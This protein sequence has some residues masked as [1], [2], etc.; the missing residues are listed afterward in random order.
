M[1]SSFMPRV[2]AALI[3]AVLGLSGCKKDAPPPPSTSTAIVPQAT[4]IEVVKEQER[5]RNFL[6]VS[7]HL[8]LGGTVYGYLDIDGDVFKV[9]GGLQDFATQLGRTQPQL[10]PLAK[11][12][13]S[14]LAT[15]LGLA[16]I[17]AIGFSSV[18]DGTGAFRNRTFL[19]TP[20][21][22]HGLLASLGGAPGAFTHLK[23][24]PADASFYTESEV[25]LAVAWK[26]IH[27]VIAK[28]GG[29][30]ATTQV[31]QAMAK[32]GEGIALS[33][34][35]LIYGLKGHASVVLRFDAA[36]PLVL[37]GASSAPMPAPL[38][39]IS[40]DG[41][42]PVVEKSLAQA[43]AFQR[44]DRGTQHLYVL[45]QKLPTGVIQPV[46]V[47]DGNTLH[48]AT[49]LDFFDE[50]TK[51][52]AGL[53][54]DA[55]FKAALGSVGGQGN[56]L[57]YVSPKFFSDLRTLLK[58]LPNIPP[59]GQQAVNALAQKLPS[60]TRPM[61]SVRTNLPDGILIQSSWD[62]SL[63]QDIV[64]AGAANPVT[65]GFFAAMAIPAFQKVR[66]ASQEKAILN[67][68]RQLDAAAEQFYL[69]NGVRAASYNDLV[70][71]TRYIR[72]LQSVMGEDYRR[73]SFAQGVPLRLVLPDGRIIQYPP[74]EMRQMPAP[75]P[76]AAPRP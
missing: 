8:E 55:A 51:Q 68:L 19:Y 10:A 59:E 63:K 25:D 70:G 72:A 27:E 65:I 30:V 2:G 29:E 64:M 73:L 45:K 61:I 76:P 54:D 48:L 7:K 38:L 49:S 11:L 24:A 40:V 43:Q 3:A 1:K 57:T 46:L 66:T 47:A 41:V 28:A 32:A 62:R 39:L 74:A 16:D 20:G 42:A 22:R 15:T 69:E 50:C 6:A 37:P 18:P 58:S 44:T 23:L 75:R 67:N 12:N 13:L 9:M 17:K 34:L 60:G 35:D 4:T 52:Q 53:A 56:A 71:P 21:E 26:T 36:H 31:D 33:V 5:S 14:E